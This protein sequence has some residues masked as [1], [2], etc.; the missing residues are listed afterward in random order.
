VIS[1][2]LRSG[3]YPA[4]TRYNYLLAA[5]QLAR[6]L[7]ERAGEPD[8]A[9][10]ARGP[11]AVTRRHVEAFQTWMVETRS[12]AT[13]LN[14]HKALQQCFKWLMV[15]EEEI[16]QSPMLRVRQPKTQTAH[17][18]HPG[19][20]HEEDPGQLQGPGL[21]PASRRSDHPAA[22]QHRDAAVRGGQP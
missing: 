18:D 21:R 6:Y 22:V 8:T 17:P 3:N 9:D 13:A 16:D 4:T 20:G 15:D 7:A 14:K 10:A 11:T 5:A 2:S 19:R 12:A 1:G